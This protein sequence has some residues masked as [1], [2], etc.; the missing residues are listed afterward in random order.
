MQKLKYVKVPPYNNIIIFPD[1]IQHAEFQLMAPI[2]A[3]FCHIDAKNQEIV[4][5]GDSYSLQL[6]S[7][8]RQDSFEATKQ[9]FG[10]DAA[11]KL[12]PIT[13]VNKTI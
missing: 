3:G 13:T 2:S 12:L 6:K 11:I 10:I 1:N 8:N 4:C 7:D 9:F 5:Y